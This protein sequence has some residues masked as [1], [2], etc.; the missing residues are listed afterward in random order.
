MSA[1]SVAVIGSGATKSDQ[2]NRYWMQND[3][4]C[5]WPWRSVALNNSACLH[6]NS[7]WSRTTKRGSLTSAL[8]S[9]QMSCF[10]QVLLGLRRGVFRGTYLQP[11]QSVPATSQGQMG[12]K[13]PLDLVCRSLTRIC[14]GLLDL[15]SYLLQH[16]LL[17]A[18]TV[19]SASVLYE[20]NFSYN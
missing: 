10:R 6:S 4:P 20:C 3:R 9:Y 14:N 19:K 17:L 5:M 13:M 1:C 12:D 15:L 16:Q 18:E 11:W 7:N 2:T 8:Y